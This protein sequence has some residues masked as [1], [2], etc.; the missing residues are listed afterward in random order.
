MKE[1]EIQRLA[2]KCS[3]RIRMGAMATLKSNIAE[4]EDVTVKRCRTLTREVVMIVREGF[5]TEAL[6]GRKPRVELAKISNPLVDDQV[7]YIAETYGTVASEAIDRMTAHII[8]RV[9]SEISS[10]I[11]D[12]AHVK[13]GIMRLRAAF[14][15]AGVTVE[16]PALIET[17]FRTQNAIAQSA[18]RLAHDAEVG[19]ILWGYRYSTAGDDRVRPSHEELDGMTLPVDAPEW[20]TL[21]PPN[22]YNCRCRLIPLYEKPDKLVDAPDGAEPDKNFDFNPLE[23]VLRGEA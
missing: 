12:G 22:G 9:K 17:L 11:A 7:A 15:A 6:K 3:L 2:K 23:V 5:R 8:D 20:E 13:E 16:R 14:D 21:A 4:V 18:G 10:I 19:D 1:R